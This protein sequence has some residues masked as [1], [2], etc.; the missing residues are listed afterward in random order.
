MRRGSGEEGTEVASRVAENETNPPSI[1][2]R[3]GAQTDRPTGAR[4]TAA[5]GT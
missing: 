3:G 1:A 5:E 4:K 2:G